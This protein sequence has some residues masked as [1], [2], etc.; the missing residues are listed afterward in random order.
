[1]SELIYTTTG[2]LIPKSDHYQVYEKNA[3]PLEQLFSRSTIASSELAVLDFYKT[4]EI[5]T[6]LQANRL[7]INYIKNPTFDNFIEILNF[8]TEIF[9]SISCREF[10]E[11]QVTSLH[12]SQMTLMLCRD[13]VDGNITNYYQYAGVSPNSRFVINNGVTETKAMENLKKIFPNS[14]QKF[15]SLSW[16]DILTPVVENKSAFVTMFKHLFVDYY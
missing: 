12:I 13:I 14:R 10:F 15:S 6:S 4:N 7:Y 3:S 5:Y 8:A 9:E 11:A 2:I 1:M 16:V